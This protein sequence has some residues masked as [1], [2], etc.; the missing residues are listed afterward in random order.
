MDAIFNKGNVSK[1]EFD[2]ISDINIKVQMRDG[3]KLNVNVFRPHSSNKF[4][5]LIGLA[6]VN[7]DIQD[8]RI[9]P[10]AARSSRVNGT[11]TVEVESI[12]KDFFV[13]RGYVKVV[14]SSRGTGKSEGVYEYDSLEEKQDIFELIEWTARQTWCNGNVGMAG[15]AEFAAIE[16]LVAALQ[17]PHLKAIAPLFSWWDDYRYFWWQGGILANGFLKWTHNLV[18][19]DIH[20][21]RCEL[22][23][24]LGEKKFKDLV[25]KAL[26][27]KDI[28]SDPGL[29]EILKNPLTLS[30]AVILDI[31]LHS[32]MGS[33]WQER[34]AAIDFSR[35][36]IPAYMGVV[37]HRPGPMHHWSQLQIPK[38]M[39]YVPPAYVDRPFYQLS[40]ELLRW[41]DYWLKGI[42][43]GIMDDPSVKIFV[44][45]SNEWLNTNDFPV[46]GTR[47]IPFALHENH[48]LCEIEPWP[49]AQSASY[50]DSPT[51]R[52]SLKYYSA[53]L[54][55]NTEVVG[56]GSL[57]LYAS[58]RGTD[59]N[60]FASLWD[61]DQEGKETCLC[62][63]YLRA[64]H[65]ELDPMLSKPYQPVH[66]H[67]NPQSLVPGQVYPLSI[68]F[69]P[70]ANLFKAG[71]RIMLKISSADDEP[72][73]LFQ[74]GMYHL[75]SQ[76]P[77]TITVYHEAKYPS[78]LL[79]P[80]TKGNIIGTYVSG[81]DIGL[82]NREFMKLN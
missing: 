9:W 25:S 3:I 30:H 8:S 44:N 21:D 37:S 24:E 7:L 66:T 45:G 42:D 23:D 82:K 63:G 79:L 35:I 70:I 16:P 54:V 55:E 41:F 78:H 73:N 26:E 20:T 60:I 77:N 75:C 22:L 68:G 53:P 40:W 38:K 47:W 76:T 51:N 65:R 74:V 14:G 11:P 33:Y 2:I 1:R 28:N 5:A 6:P 64:S 34:G 80:V 46:P 61:S 17:P 69:S 49:E 4:P 13:R 36:K 71:H 31:L 72:E 29:V 67:I 81:G 39:I 18:N 12:P 56:L 48:S 27:D 15:I 59:M 32:E 43:T 52:G 50:D 19:K 10:S 58:C 57:N 62:R